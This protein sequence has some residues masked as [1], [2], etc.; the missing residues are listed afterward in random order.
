MSK[1]ESLASYLDDFLSRGDEIAFADR[2]GLRIK[3][4]SYAEIATTA[5]QFA[6]ELEIRGIGK[7]DRVL[8]WG[9][10]S[11]EW[12][13]GFFGCVVRGAIA[14]P[15]DSQSDPG[16]VTRV[17]DQVRAKLALSGAPISGTLPTVSLKELKLHIQGHATTPY[18]ANTVSPGDVV[19]IVFTSGT[20]A[21]PKGVA[22]THRNLLANLNPLEDEI[23]KYLKW[24]RLVHPVRFLNLVPLS[25]VF[26]QFMGIFVPQMLRG[27][28]FFQDSLLPT[29]MIESVKREHIS[30]VVCVPRTLESLREKIERDYEVRNE[31]EE[32]RRELD[33]SVKSH[34]SIRWW[35]FRRIHRLFGWKFWAFISGGAALNPDTEEF[36]QTL[37][38]AV[39]QGYGMTETAA[40]ISVNHPFKK[41]GGSIGKVLP[42]QE[43]KLS[44][45]GEILVRGA[46][47]S[48]GYWHDAHSS[49]AE[50]GWF[51]TGDKGVMDANG[52]LYFKGRSKEVIVTS[53]GMNIYP[54]D[55]E[56]ALNRQREIKRSAVVEIDG[57]HGPEPLAVLILR[58]E[59]AQAGA[60]IE[61]ANTTLA[62]H[63]QVRRWAV[64]PDPEFP[65]T[66]TQKVRKQVIA[67]H[68][69]SQVAT[70]AAAGSAGALERIIA[71]VGGETAQ[72]IDPT[73]KLGS[74]LKLDSLG[75]VELLSALE[76][77]YQVELDEAAFTE[78][79]TIG[80]V[81]KLIRA[82]KHETS[83]RYPYPRWQQQWPLNWLR[84]ALLYLVVW[85]FTR[86]MARPTIRGYEILKDLNTPLVFVCNHVTMVDHALVLHALPGSI[87]RRVSI[88][89]DGELL[90]EWRYPS[91][92]TKFF[93]RLVH[94]AEYLLTVLFFNVFSM[95]KKSGFRRS[96]EFAGEMMDRGYNVL[97]FPEG[98]R[99]E[100][101][102]LNRFQPGTGLLISKLNASVVPF[103]IDGLAELKDAN[104]RVAKTGEII[105]T[106]GK[107]VR[108]ANQTS[109]EVIV[110]DLEKRI[111]EL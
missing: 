36:W 40:V 53:A 98:E 66:S 76:D 93:T 83:S 2:D 8:L 101:G 50:D 34:P 17:Q 21:E 33:R 94:L 58:D 10:N 54:E 97:V 9:R 68:I 49:N 74:D 65:L 37:G 32:F 29:K 26:G 16:F 81:E 27:E 90:R 99:T 86:F 12:V 59:K 5:F 7:G 105:V 64:W 95:P 111:R 39:I 51:P 19:E 41:A 92:P 67:Q 61:R 42:G 106:V 84:I 109:P 85:P 45:E 91:Y 78:A 79:T 110:C 77:E 62:Q 52:N 46:N 23:R 107:P 70:G 55:I 13:S 57:P 47:V 71:H 22:I 69:K 104:R 28:V 80:E 89:M 73:A 30:V 87:R 75:R 103:R 11:P 35:R 25:H 31:L 44:D 56:L 6:R 60:V 20:T 43:V 100:H 15:I 48:S 38:F 82:D 3:R 96:F 72:R 63:Q 108:Y 102:K 24:E 18:S 88:A 14:V 1:R 4:F